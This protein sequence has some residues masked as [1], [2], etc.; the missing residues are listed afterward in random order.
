MALKDIYVMSLE[1]VRGACYRVD[2]LQIM[3]LTVPLR[4]GFMKSLVELIVKVKS[5]C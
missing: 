3:L 5:Y 1:T 2:D 4:V